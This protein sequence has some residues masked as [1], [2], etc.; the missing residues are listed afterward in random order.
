MRR[1]VRLLRDAGISVL[2]AG[3]L[4]VI[5]EGI[6]RILSPSSGDALRIVQGDDAVSQTLGW[7]DLN[8]APLD[9]DV[10][11]L[12]RNRPDVQKRQPV[13]PQAFGRHDEWTIVSNARGQLTRA[14]ST[15]SPMGPAIAAARSSTGPAL[16]KRCDRRYCTPTIASISALMAPLAGNCLSISASLSASNS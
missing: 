8:L 5:V 16:S 6:S 7:L 4:L 10:D 13:N 2:V 9:K 15:G 3:V 12:W 14:L 1:S 11:F